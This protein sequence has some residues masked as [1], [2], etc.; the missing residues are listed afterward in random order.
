MLRKGL[1]QR[2]LVRAL[3]VDGR[4]TEDTRWPPPEGR[5]GRVYS[6][7]EEFWMISTKLAR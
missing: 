6:G 4:T 7:H 5:Q 1:G 2:E 3:I